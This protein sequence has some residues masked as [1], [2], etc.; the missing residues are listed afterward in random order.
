MGGNIFQVLIA[1]IKA[2]IMPLY[3]KLR[4]YTNLNY[5]NTRFLLRIREFFIKKLSVK[6]RDKKDYY[7]IFG[8]L[9]SKRLAFAV[10]MVVGV[11]SVYY[12]TVINPVF[13]R[14]GNGI[15]TYYYNALPLRFA[16]GQVKIRAKSG[17]L[18][19]EGN[20]EKGAVTGNGMLYGVSGNLI[21]SGM[22]DQNEYNGNGKLFYD[23]SN[24][25]YAGTFANNLYE[26]NGILYRS[27]GSTEYDGEF[28]LGMKEGAGSLFDTGNNL[29]Y[30]GNFS[31]DHL[32][33]T[34]LL[35]KST[36][37]VSKMYTGQRTIYQD[38]AYMAVDMPD[39]EA[40]YCADANSSSLDDSTLV[41]SVYVLQ[42]SFFYGGKTYESIAD[43]EADIPALNYE[44]N[45]ELIMPEA[46]A[47]QN[48]HERGE[49]MFDAVRIDSERIFDD[50]VQVN[51]FD[52][53][54][55]GYIY[56]FI[57]EGMQYSFMCAERYGKFDFYL[58]EK[59]S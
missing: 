3:T 16:K 40:M 25:C 22:F 56:S 51:D 33:Y 44:G 7:S 47:I 13:Q 19:Y 36:Q 54:H 53:D 6:P 27:G 35:G 58:I 45:I 29:V 12:L 17:Y 30:H 46:I 59:I 9:V 41:E 31:Q 26:G 49:C 4:L 11:I 18:A 2:H 52:M 24:L 1:A 10:T 23:N 34:D 15:R 57:D 37:E 32:L 5:L 20:V 14:D 8:W 39:I 28:S 48:L 50:A 42:N 38:D 43:L 21:Y 55:Y